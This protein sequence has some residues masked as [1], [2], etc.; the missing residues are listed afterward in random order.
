MIADFIE[1]SI[2]EK[3]KKKHPIIVVNEKVLKEAQLDKQN[4]YK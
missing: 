3:K 2:A 4:F 1:K